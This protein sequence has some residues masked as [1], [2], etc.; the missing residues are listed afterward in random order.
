MALILRV[1]QQLI[2]LERGAGAVDAPLQ[3]FTP[4]SIELLV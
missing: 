4:I 3:C 2:F 1:F